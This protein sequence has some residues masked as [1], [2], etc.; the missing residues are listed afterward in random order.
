MDSAQRVSSLLSLVSWLRRPCWGVRRPGCFFNSAL[1]EGMG[2]W[3]APPG[4]VARCDESATCS[5]AVALLRSVRGAVP[6]SGSAWSLCSADLGSFSEGSG[7]TAEWEC[8]QS[9]NGRRA[10]LPRQAPARPEQRVS[11]L[12]AA[13]EPVRSAGPGSAGVVERSQPKMPDFSV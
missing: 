1:L 10:R 6:D 7:E 2:A 12:P 11:R 8:A 9:S 5:R 3:P 13:T 4:G